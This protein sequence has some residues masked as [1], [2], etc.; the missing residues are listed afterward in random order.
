MIKSDDP[1]VNAHGE[2]RDREIVIHRPRQ[3]LEMMTQVV[4]EEPRRSALKR[5]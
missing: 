2:I 3:P 4:A 1:I 5:R